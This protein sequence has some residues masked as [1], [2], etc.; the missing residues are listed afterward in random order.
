MIVVPDVLEVLSTIGNWLAGVGG[1]VTAIMALYLARRDVRVNLKI[2]V[3]HEILVTPGLKETQDYCSVRIVNVGL[4]PANITNIG[5][6]VGFFRRRYGIQTFHAHPM[7]G[8]LPTKL[9]SGEEVSYLVG[10]LD[11]RYPYWLDE[12]KNSF[13]PYT[14]KISPLTMRIQV[15][16]SIGQ[17]FQ[18][19]IEKS[20]QQ[21]LAGIALKQKNK[22]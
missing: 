15:H 10:F 5:W 21:K 8:K 20:L 16:T 17:V 1:T 2:S 3:D 6:R 7:S 12:I 11:E 18:A 13:L 4:R 19:K 22:R 14:P 9:D